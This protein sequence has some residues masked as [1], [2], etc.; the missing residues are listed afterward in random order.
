MFR[1]R[2]VYLVGDPAGKVL[3]GKLWKWHLWFLIQ[4]VV[5]VVIV[6]LLEESVICCLEEDHTNRKG[7]V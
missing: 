4:W 1:R 7:H 5:A 2:H 3:D 6:T